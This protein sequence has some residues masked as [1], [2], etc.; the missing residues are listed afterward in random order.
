[1]ATTDYLKRRG[2]T[3][4]VR[5]QIPNHLWNAA[6]GK[7]EYVK[8]LKTGDLH[9]ANRLKHAHVAGFKRKIEALERGQP[10]DALNELYEK[11]T[12]WRDTL[13]RHKGE[14][15]FYEGPD[16]DQPFY[17]NDEYLSQISEEAQ[18]FLETHGERAA[19]A[20]FKIAKGEGTLLSSQVDIWLAE[21]SGTITAQT[22]AQHRTVIRA[23][24]S[25]AGSG[26]LI[27]D[28]T[29]RYAGQFV[30]HLLTPTSGLSR[31]TARRYVSSLSSF[32]RWLRARGLATENP[33]REQELGKKSTRGEPL[34][35]K[36]WSD[37]ALVKVLSGTYTPRYTAILHDLVRLA[38]VS[39]ARLD[40]LCAL[41]VSD[42]HKREDGWWINIVEGKTEAARREVPI[43]RSAAHVLMRRCKASRNFV[44][45]GLMPGGPDKKRSWNVSKAFGHYTRK[46]ELASKGRPNDTGTQ[47]S[48]VTV[49]RS[50]NTAG[51]QVSL[52]SRC[53]FDRPFPATVIRDRTRS[54]VGER[55]FC[56]PPQSSSVM[57][58]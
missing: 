26:V 29:K 30:S 53:A 2:Q 10:S 57:R 3:W 37:E 17:L 9:E 6:G 33:W 21:Q 8:T 35:R 19:S 50:K 4:F 1:M 52:W 25:W 44:F 49:P 27:E 34:A 54:F 18:E 16:K 41:K 40:E 24:T 55:L 15:L 31:K 12:A 32:W 43:H 13:E 47:T 58:W 5:V 36:Q 51:S 22:S 11:A 20:F 42:V 7:R 28:V 38:L 48:Q 23:F 14:V 45:E 39:G 46:L 56:F